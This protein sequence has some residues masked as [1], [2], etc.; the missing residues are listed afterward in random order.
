M[1]AL[2]KK[3]AIS[4]RYQ[5]PKYFIFELIIGTGEHD[6]SFLHV[7]GIV[8]GVG[9]VEIRVGVGQGVASSC[10]DKVWGKSPTVVPIS[11]NPGIVFLLSVMESQSSPSHG[12]IAD[13]A[14][15][16]R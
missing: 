5:A 4:S 14:E 11:L 8:P 2:D 12:E 6:P 15:F 9:Y 13:W 10:R 3:Q 7:E 16:R 1:N